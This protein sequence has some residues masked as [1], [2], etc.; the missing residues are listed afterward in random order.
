MTAKSFN[1]LFKIFR[2][3]VKFLYPKITISGKENLP[4][5]PVILV[6]NH[7]QMHGPICCEIYPPRESRTWC[8]AEMLTVR[9]VPKYAY[10]DFWWVKPALS[11]PFYKFLSYIIAPISAIIFANANTIPVWRNKRVISTFKQTVNT[12]IEGKD[13]I[14][15]PEKNHLENNILCTFQQNFVDVARLYYKRTGKVLS[16]VPMY[17]A[18]RLNK[19]CLGTA[20]QYDPEN[21]RDLERAHLRIFNPPNYPNGR[22]SSPPP[23]CALHKF[24]QKTSTL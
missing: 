9:E 6:A 17:I 22:R 15:F 4:E 11:K 14:I 13:V 8:A 18:P 24:A 19:I 16:F 21:D 5:E 1:W 10:H 3:I 20:I 2:K 12:L 7:A 23:Y